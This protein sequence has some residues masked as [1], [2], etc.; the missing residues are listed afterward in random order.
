[1]TLL[2]RLDISDTKISNLLPAAN[3]VSLASAS[4]GSPSNGLYFRNCP[5]ADK[6]V[7]EQTRKLNPSR[8]FDTLNHVRRLLDLPELPDIPQQ[9]I[10]PHF[11]F[12]TKG[13][14]TFADP[15]DVD[16]AGNNIDRLK[17]LHPILKATT[18]QLVVTLANTNAHQNIKLLAQEYL[19]DIEKDLKDISFAKIYGIGLRLQNASAASHR[20]VSRVEPE[21][22]DNLRESLDSLVDL[23]GLFILSSH[24]GLELT[25]LAERYRRQPADDLA[26]REAALILGKRLEAH[27]EIADKNVSN[28]V[29]ETAEA[30]GGGTQPERAT[31]YGV[32]TFVNISIAIAVGAISATALAAGGA[33]AL[34][35]LGGAGATILYV[36]K[37]ILKKSKVYDSFTGDAAKSLDNVLDHAPEIVASMGHVGFGQY[38]EFVRENK[39]VLRQ[40]AGDR[41][42]FKWLLE[43]VNWV[44][45]H[46]QKKG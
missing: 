22:E 12:N 40:L 2:E 7:A 43:H 13:A 42:Q 3:L 5:I 17:K 30:I 33:V 26:F 6:Y 4:R 37:D 44:E 8:T 18:R 24:E 21:L 38:L 1:M 36:S 23:H 16:E 46:E 45:R 39:Q 11:A 29:R 25:E 28:F 10:G 27:P 32:G 31:V 14:I 20:Q 34:A 15:S 9:A 35:V 19:T 41:P